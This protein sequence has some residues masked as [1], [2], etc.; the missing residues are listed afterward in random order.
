MPTSAPVQSNPLLSGVVTSMAK[1]IESVLVI[2]MGKVG[3]LVATLL[4]EQGYRVTGLD[5]QPPAESSF[6]IRQGE[7]GERALPRDALAEHDA[8]VSCLPYHWNLPVART[9]HRLGRHYFDLTEDVAT[10]A[11]IQD[12]AA[13]ARAV[14][15]PQCGLAP[16]FISIVGAE[17]ASRF[18]QLRSIELR[19]GALPQHPRGLLGYAFNWSPEGVVNEYLNP[20]EVIAD[21]RRGQVP[22]M[23]ELETIIIDGVQL[24]AFTTSGGLGSMCD[25]FE[26]KVETLNYKTIRYLG[27][28]KLMRFFFHEL[29]M[30]YDRKRAGEILVHAKPPVNDDVVYVHAAVEGQQRGRLFR[31]EFVRA[32]YPQPIAGQIRPAIAWTT[33]CSVAAVLELVARGELPASGFIRQ[34][35]IPLKAFFATLS[36]AL[37]R[38]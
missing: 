27:H 24:E 26:G 12:L 7:I 21:G 32:Y 18:E 14:M 4:H 8:V 9:A 2:G 34:E 17:L 6:E 33:A 23:E 19:V 10:T 22:A 11:A 20:C 35:K 16:G 38:K 5:R 29:L 13:T 3:L 30:K 1:N 31:E 25:S 36:G 15:A 28:C 37:F